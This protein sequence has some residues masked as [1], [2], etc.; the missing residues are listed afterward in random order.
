MS[1]D[2]LHYYESELT[3]IRHLAGEFAQKYP[4]VAGRLDF[5]DSESADPHVERLIQAFAMLTGRIRHKI[6]DEFPEVVESLLNVMYPHYLRPLPPMAIG[7]F[8]FDA[9]Q[10]RPTEAVRIPAQSVLHSKPAGGTVGTFRTCYPVT[11]WPLRITGANLGSISAAGVGRAPSEAASVLRIQIDA[12][13]GLSPAAMKIDSLRFYLNGDGSPIYRL[14]ELLLTQVT[15]IQVRPRRGQDSV[16][17]LPGTCIQP[18]GFER[19]EGLLPYPDRSFLGYRLLEEYFAFPQKFLFVDILGLGGVTLTGLNSGFDLLLFFRDS[20]LRDHLPAISQVVKAETFQLGC[21]PVVNLFEALADPLRVSHAVTE[22]RIIPDL[23][24]QST[25]EVYSVDRVS[26]AAAYSEE[27]QVY[28]P[29]YSFRHGH[30]EGKSECFWYAHRRASLRKGD[31]GTE[32]YLSLV[33]LKFNPTL[34]PVELISA[35][36][37]CTNRDFISRLNWQKEWG[38][39]AGEGLP[40]VQARCLV[41]PTPAVRPPLRGALQWR[42]ISHLALNRLSIVQGGGLEALREILRLYC[43]DNDEDARK[44]IAGLSALKS[45]STV[46]RVPFENGVTFCR[47]L[48]VEVEFDEEQFTG[49][50]AY[51]LASVLDRFFGLYSA[52]NSYS[53]LTAR[54]TQRKTPIHRWPARIGQQ[55]VL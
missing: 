16:Q 8:Q 41:K 32:V 53:R 20:E 26:S 10:S 46:S 33:D 44:R 47:G 24:R 4:K 13:G 51:L 7:Q 23:H 6:E 39:I 18:V 2:L 34:P 3:F 28:E 49:S 11:V 25:T 40:M 21:S 35:T 29:L 15:A 22:Y 30:S 43:F 5:H 55:R 37:T 12:L 52:M 42:L 54:S 36:V 27:S 1:Q 31:D 14:Y 17:D 48:D 45:R 9:Q 50:G 38:E 19:D